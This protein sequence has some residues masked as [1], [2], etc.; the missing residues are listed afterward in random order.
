MNTHFLAALPK[1][2]SENIA[3]MLKSCIIHL[4]SCRP[5]RDPFS[6]P[7]IFIPQHA[8]SAVYRGGPW[9][10]DPTCVLHMANFPFTS[11]LFAT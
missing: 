1:K 9:V 10:V 8:C 3:P 11:P 2:M 5:G 6:C 4:P 7:I